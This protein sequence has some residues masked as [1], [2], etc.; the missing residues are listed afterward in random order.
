VIPIHVAGSWICYNF[1][2]DPKPAKITPFGGIMKKIRRTALFLI[3]MAALATGIHALAV[4]SDKCVTLVN[5]T[6][7]EAFLCCPNGPGQPWTC[8]PTSPPFVCP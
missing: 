3:L 1:S 2:G 8:V 5:Q 6:T 7:C 4:P